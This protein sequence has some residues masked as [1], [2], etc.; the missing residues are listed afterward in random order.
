MHAC[1]SLIGGEP[2]GVQT[3]AADAR[4]LSVLLHFPGGKAAQLNLWTGKEV[5]PACRFQ[6]V[7]EAGEA[8]AELPRTLRWRDGDGSHTARAP[9]RSTPQLLVERFLDALAAGTP[10]APSLEDAYRALS[11][12]RAALQT[13]GD[14]PNGFPIGSPSQ[15]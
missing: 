6:A 15:R 13:L 8:M 9:R 12:A 14:R 11:W 1:A 3:A 5:H 10:P 4:F 7:T 2:I